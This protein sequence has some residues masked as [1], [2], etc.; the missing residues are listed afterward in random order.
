MTTSYQRIHGS[1]LQKGLDREHEQQWN[2][3]QHARPGMKGLRAKRIQG[4]YSIEL[5]ITTKQRC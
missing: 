2:V 4:M 3:T 1:A 5:S